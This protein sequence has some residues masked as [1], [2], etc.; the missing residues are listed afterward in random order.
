MLLSSRCTPICPALPCP[1]ETWEHTG[2]CQCFKSS[3]QRDLLNPITKLPVISLCSLCLPPHNLLSACKH[4][5][6]NLHS[7]AS[8]WPAS[9]LILDIYDAFPRPALIKIKL[10]S[11]W[12]W[13]TCRCDHVQHGS[14]AT[15]SSY[16]QREIRLN[17]TFTGKE[18]HHPSEAGELE[19]DL[20]MW[21]SESSEDFY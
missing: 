13:W 4:P 7:V 18:H 20:V 10:T 3:H 15:H 8:Q 5:S 12:A 14:V 11:H 1:G 9:A 21:Q 2:R 16:L 6:V 17:I 19:A